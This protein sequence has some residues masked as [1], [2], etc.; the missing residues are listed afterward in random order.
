MT[1]IQREDIHIITKHSNWSEKSIDHILKKDIY[2]DRD[3][4]HKFLKLFLISLGVGFTTAGII[5]FFA[6]NWA[7]LHKFIKIGLIE[8]L[9]IVLTLI[10][11]YSRINLNTKN[12]LLTGVS[13]L[14]GVLFAVFGQIYQTGANAY[15]FFL[16]WTV[17][18]TIWVLISNFAPLWLIYITLINTT[19]ILYWQQVAHD[20]S[21]IFIF[22]LLILINFLFLIYS[23]FA[24]KINN[25]FKFP[26]WFTNLLALFTVCLSTIGIIYNIFEYRESTISTLIL[27]VTTLYITG[28]S[29][30]LKQKKAFYLLII[31]FSIIIII[32]AFL[33]KLSNNE[34]MFFFISLFVIGSVTFVIKNLINLQKK[35]TN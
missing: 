26:N 28:I 23:L 17:F 31:P 13:V 15:D 14:A 35:W 6:Y 24:H 5:F 11:L 29:Y 34:G 30:G 16:G 22:T 32:S 19:I 25:D 9:I 10:I 3:S 7:N 20:W 33:I 12:I 18:I 1:K 8:S 4:W 27:I 21:I 2:N